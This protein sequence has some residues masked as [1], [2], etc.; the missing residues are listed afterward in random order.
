M[1]DEAK[2]GVNIQ[3]DLVT[4]IHAEV[5]NIKKLDDPSKPATSKGVIE[6]DYFIIPSPEGFTAKKFLEG[7]LMEGKFM[8]K[9]TVIFI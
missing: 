8:I 4:A 9:T 7:F 5:D 1:S 3:F 2:E 6:T